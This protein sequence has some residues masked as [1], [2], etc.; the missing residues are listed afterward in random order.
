MTLQEEVN[1]ELMYIWM[2]EKN[3]IILFYPFQKIESCFHS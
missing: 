3:Q 2:S 1:M